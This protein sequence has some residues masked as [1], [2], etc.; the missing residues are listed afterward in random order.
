MQLAHQDSPPTKGCHTHRT[1]LLCLYIAS[2]VMSD[3]V[4]VLSCRL[5][6]VGWHDAVIKHRSNTDSGADIN[7]HA[8]VKCLCGNGKHRQCQEGLIVNM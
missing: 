4:V 3:P 6:T 8:E 5:C 2:D 7:A 1:V